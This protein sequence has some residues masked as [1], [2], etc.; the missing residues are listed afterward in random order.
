MQETLTL[1]DFELDLLNNG[2]N[3]NAY[4]TLGSHKMEIN[5]KIGYRFS[6]WAPN[7]SRVS[8]VGD[9]NQWN[10][11]CHSMQ[12]H[13]DNGVWELF[14]EAIDDDSLYK[15]EIETKSGEI[16]LKQDPYGFYSELRPNTA[17]ITTNLSFNWDDNKWLKN[18]VKS[19]PYDKPISIYEVH[20]GS[21]KRKNKTEFYTYNDLADELIPY[22]LE[23][24]YT[25]IEIMPLSEHLNDG[26]FGYHSSG[27]YS[28]TSRYGTPFDFMTFINKCHLNGICVI[29]DWIP[30][31]FSKD[32]S[33][34]SRFDG[35]CLYEYEDIHNWQH[36]DWGIAEFNLKRPEVIS[37]LISNAFFWF[38]IYH[39]DG[40]RVDSISKMLYWDYEKNDGE[41]PPNTHGTNEN[42]EAIDFIKRLNSAVH[43]EFPNVLTVC[44]DSNGWRGVT[45]PVPDGGL[46]FSFKW[47]TS[48]MNDILTYI[49]MDPLFR[50]HHHNALTFS[51]MYAF[52]ENNILPMPHDVVINEKKSLIDKMWG[53]YWQKFA[54]LR[55][56]YAYMYAHPGKKLQFMGGEFGQ[57]IE[58]NF[59][60]SLDWHLLDYEMH[61]KMLDFFKVLN[62]FYRN[63]K[64]FWKDDY[65]WKGFQWINSSDNEKSII[66]F[67]RMTKLKQSKTIVICN[68][69]PV[70]YKKYRIGIPIKGIYQEVLNTDNAEFGG[71]GIGNGDLI[72]ENIPFDGLKYSFEIDLPPLAVLYIKKK[73]TL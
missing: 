11:N 22:V 73:E 70:V 35:T 65:S 50:K 3:Y 14:I 30:G 42:L 21:W 8:V 31:Y 45:K 26:S 61:G 53:D 63:E 33:S 4:K 34:L 56:F 41:F 62:H 17:S 25:H 9:F 18:R 7:A 12:K 51:L 72:T 66:S 38:D 69:T 43:Q 15:Y 47:N 59:K 71:S 40:L 19:Q 20:I 10:G 2:T 52:N 37:F 58:W 64:S 24:G 39:I 49:S 23:M 32:A 54:G 44:G 29:L 28:L 57:F 46:G 5:G 36:N 68:F 55:M 1:T 60:D 67:Y 48:W 6:V 27:F 16:F 13:S